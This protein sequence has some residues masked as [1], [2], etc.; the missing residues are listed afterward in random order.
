MIKL[1][2]AS[3]WDEM[4]KMVLEAEPQLSQDDINF[5]EG[6]DEALVIKLSQTLNRTHEQIIG[7]VESVSSNAVKA[8]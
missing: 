5:A 8:S 7:W 4:K 3:G 6:E 1:K 2:L